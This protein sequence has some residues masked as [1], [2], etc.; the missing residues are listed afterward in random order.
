MT[1]KDAFRNALRKADFNSVR[2]E[3]RFNNNQHPINNWVGRVV[4]R[5]EAGKLVNRTLNVV[6]ANHEDAYAKDCAL[7]WSAN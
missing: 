4:E 5:N 7:K 3:F 6:S 1:A 2:G